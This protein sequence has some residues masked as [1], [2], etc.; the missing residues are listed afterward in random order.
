MATEMY[1]L[2]ACTA[3]MPRGAIKD[4][5]RISLRV[6]PEQKATLLRT[7]ALKHTDLTEFVL[8]HALSAAGKVIEEAEQV[9]LSEPDSVRVLELLEHPPVPHARLLAA[10]RALTEHS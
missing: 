8:Q 7:A 10:A 2:N 5:S 4:R 1:N 6:R 3:I 9:Q